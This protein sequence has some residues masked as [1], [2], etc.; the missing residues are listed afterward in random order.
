MGQIL[1][2]PITTKHSTEG[3]DAR[4][5]YGAS[6]MQGWRICMSWN[7]FIDHGWETNQVKNQR[8]KMLIRIYYNIKIQVPPFSLYLMDTE[9]FFKPFTHDTCIY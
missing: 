1:S 4:L 3:G 6:S 2:S 8:W 7:H 9:V 5:L